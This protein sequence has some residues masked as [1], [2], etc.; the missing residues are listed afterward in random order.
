MKSHILTALSI[1]LG[2]FTLLGGCS[3]AVTPTP[4][5]GWVGGPMV[6]N[7]TSPLPAWTAGKFTP[8][9]LQVTGGVSPYTWTLK[10]GSQLPDGFQLYTDG[11][12]TGTP[13]LLSPGAT[14]YVAPPFTVIIQDSV[15]QRIEV[16]LKI[17]IIQPE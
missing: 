16:E 15:G 8:A 2:V 14:A 17:T 10:S 5:T 3:P 13:P 4:T 6:F 9:L 12:L 7:D 1:L 11:K